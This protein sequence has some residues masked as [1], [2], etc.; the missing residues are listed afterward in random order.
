MYSHHDIIQNVLP[1]MPSCE[2]WLICNESNYQDDYNVTAEVAKEL[3]KIVLCDYDTIMTPDSV[4]KQCEKLRELIERYK[5][6]GEKQK[7]HSKRTYIFLGDSVIGNYTGSLS[8]PGVVAYMTGADVINCGYGG[9]AATK[10]SGEN[11]GISGVLDYMLGEK[12]EHD[13]SELK[14]NTIVEGIQKFWESD[15]SKK[16]SKVTF[17]ISFGI[18]DCASNYPIYNDD[19]D[20]ACYFGALAH[21]VDR[22][23]EAYPKAE[24]VLMTPNYVEFFANEPQV[25]EVYEYFIDAVQ[26]L[27]KEEGLQ[28]ID[29]YNDLGVTADNSRLYLAD[30]IHPNYYGRFKIGEL[31]WE[32]MQ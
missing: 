1:Y 23:Q 20:D 8:I 4:Q 27:A 7:K 31:I 26:Y 16:S 9:L 10:I 17:F 5:E 22:L 30:G 2:E 21:A 18:N 6:Q 28:L 13:L 24:I 11:I 19:N 25:K 32:H 14:S 29:V 3:E 12:S 15:I